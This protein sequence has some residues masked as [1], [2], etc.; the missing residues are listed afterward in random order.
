MMQYNKLD[1]FFYGRCAEVDLGRWLTGAYA[2]PTDEPG[3]LDSPSD[4]S[5]APSTDEWATP[6]NTRLN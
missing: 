6:G 4:A 1:E 3:T 2:I 5:A